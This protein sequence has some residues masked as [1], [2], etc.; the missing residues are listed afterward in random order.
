MRFRGYGFFQAFWL[1]VSLIYTRLFFRRAKIIRLPFFLRR[2]GEF[3][4]GVNFSCGYFNRVDVFRGARLKIGDNFQM[5]DSCHIAC[6]SDVVIG[7]DVLIASRVFISDHDH[8]IPDIGQ[9]PLTSGLD[10]A[11]VSI[12]SRVWLGEGVCILKGVTIGDDVVVGAN[13]VVTKDI[14]SG[15]VCAGVPARLIKCRV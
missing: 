3:E 2:I 12:G 9:S 14:P 6:S 13:S 5:N 11:K 1:L 10:S 15:T 4:V 8:R 7:D